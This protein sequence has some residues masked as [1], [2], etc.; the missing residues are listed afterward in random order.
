MQPH[1]GARCRSTHGCLPVLYHLIHAVRPVMLN[2][3][4][5]LHKTL[6]RVQGDLSKLQA[7]NHLDIA[8]AAQSRL[9]QQIAANERQVQENAAT[10]GDNRRE[11]QIDSYQVSQIRK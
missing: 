4:Q 1:P 9:S 5:H 7:V 2:L 10:Q 3:L 11:Q 8:L 6:K